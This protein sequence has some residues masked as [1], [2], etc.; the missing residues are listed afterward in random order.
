MPYVTPP[1]TV[2]PREDVTAALALLEDVKHTVPTLKAALLYVASQTGRTSSLVRVA[3]H[4]SRRRLRH[5]HGLMKLTTE[6]EAALVSVTQ[7]F[8]VNNLALTVEQMRQLVL[9]KWGVKVSRTW[10]SRFLGRYRKQLSKRACKAL[11]DKRAGREVFDGVVDLCTELEDFLAHYHFP[12]HVIFNY[13][14]T[15]VV[16]RDDKMTLRRVEAANKERANVRSTRHQDVASLL[17]FVAAD[18]S[19]LLRVFILKRRFRKGEEAAVNFTMER[20]PSIT[21]GTWPMYYR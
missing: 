9:R 15:R 20:A 14:E 1:A 17:T 5:G 7:A 21:R 12:E 19:V 13:D 8:S 2:P 6:H 10:V 16:Q 18:G 11:A 4:R 3:Y